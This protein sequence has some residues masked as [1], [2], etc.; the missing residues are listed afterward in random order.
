MHFRKIILGILPAFI[1][2]IPV[3]AQET[4]LTEISYSYMDTLVLLAKQN[5]PKMK[6][7]EKRINISEDDLARS[8]VSWLDAVNASYL[9]NPGNSFNQTKPNFFTGFQVGII[10]NVG[11]ILQR[12]YLIRNAKND[13]EITRAE[14]AEY[15]LNLESLVKERYFIYVQKQTILKSRIQSTQDA[16]SILKVARYRFEKGEETIKDYNLTLIAFSAQNQD[17]LLTEAE[18]LIA[19]AR[20]E[21]LVG[22][23]LEDIK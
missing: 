9:Y 3:C 1:F 15:D 5:Y 19:K 8:R 11:Q 14:K 10:V 4:M 17:K 6:V 2:C 12:P 20:L 16:E 13:L 23:K 7:F 21:E 22:I 18:L